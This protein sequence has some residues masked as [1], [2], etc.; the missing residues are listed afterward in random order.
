MENV[1][2]IKTMAYG[3]KTV[4]FFLVLSV[5]STSFA[6]LKKFTMHSR[7]NCMNNESISWQAGH[8]MVLRTLSEHVSFDK[9]D[10]HV[11]DSHVIDTGWEHTWRSA[12]V[13]WG[14]GRGGWWVK[15]YHFRCIDDTAVYLKSEEVVDCSIYD[16]WWD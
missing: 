1:M 14:E 9:E 4:V 8:S 7:A 13:H 5:F 10:F 15:G 16:G 6:G 11:K 12:A 3:I 2:E